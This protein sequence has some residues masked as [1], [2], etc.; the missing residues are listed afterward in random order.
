MISL[1]ARTTE[2]GSR[3]LVHAVQPDLEPVAHGAFLM[4][5]KIAGYVLT[6]SENL[7][8]LWI[9]ANNNARNGSNVDGTGPVSNTGEVWQGI[10]WHLG[11]DRAGHNCECYSLELT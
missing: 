2:V 9:H 7:S 1:L 3:T 8:T 6:T 4:D 5:C 10:V 11:T